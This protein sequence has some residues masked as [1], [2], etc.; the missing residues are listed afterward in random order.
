[1][2]TKGNRPGNR[3][4][5][6]NKKKVVKKTMTV[7]DEMA[8]V[9]KKQ[10]EILKKA[11][12]KKSKKKGEKHAGGRPPKYGPSI[13][14]RTKEYIDSCFVKHVP[15]PVFDMNMDP[16]ESPEVKEMYKR[17]LGV[18]NVATILD[19]KLPSIEGLAMHLD[20]TRE[21][22]YDWEEKYPQFSDIVKKLRAK[23]GEMLLNN[24][25]SGTFNSSI[26]KVLL[27]K[28]DY[29]EATEVEEKVTHKIDIS[30]MLDKAYGDQTEEE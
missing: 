9:T 14:T 23:Q 26:S 11:V 24:G 4:V 10:Q 28:H 19:V 21:T 8:P 15:R 1:M 30:K 29:R 27:S 22:V 20:I 25:L 17:R 13:I 7:I 18:F 5:A 3:A 2:T 12:T 6:P 16:D